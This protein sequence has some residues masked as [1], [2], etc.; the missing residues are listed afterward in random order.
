MRMHMALTV[1][2]LVCA[3]GAALAG[4]PANAATGPENATLSPQS[5]TQHAVAA[6]HDSRPPRCRKFV[7]GRWVHRRGRN[8]FIRGYWLPRGCAH[9]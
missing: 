6:I 4:A 1:S 8:M 3:A 5:T 2:A 7:R 9:R